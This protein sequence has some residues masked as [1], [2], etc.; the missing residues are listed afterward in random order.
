VIRYHLCLNEVARDAN[1]LE[2][3]D[4]ILTL[5]PTTPEDHRPALFV[6]L[7]GVMLGIPTTVTTDVHQDLDNVLE[8]G[9]IVVQSLYTPLFGEGSHIDTLYLGDGFID[10]PSHDGLP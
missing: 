1:G 5:I 10:G 8:G 7:H 6:D 4:D 9:H 2:G 3:F